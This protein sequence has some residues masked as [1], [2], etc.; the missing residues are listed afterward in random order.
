[1]KIGIANDLHFGMTGEA[2]YNNRIFYDCVEEITESWVDAYNKEELD[3]VIVAGDVTEE[4]GRAAL[5]S[6]HRVL[7]QLTAPWYAIPGN[8]DWKSV[9]D[10]S[11]DDVLRGRRPG[12]YRR[13]EEIGMLFFNEGV[14]R[15][16]EETMNFL[17][18]PETMDLYLSAVEQD[19]PHTLLIFSHVPLV[20]HAD[21]PQPHNGNYGG[22]Y[23]NGL[24]LLEKLATLLDRRIV[25]FSAHVHFHRIVESAKWIQCTTGGMLEYPME[26]RIAVVENDRLRLSVLQGAPRKL[27]EAS[28]VQ[29]WARGNEQD[30]LG[31]FVL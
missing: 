13:Y 3:L 17:I 11:F 28:M 27:A 5:E 12:T 26:G 2:I 14:Q 15:D 9:L 1:M 24:E 22:H 31:E 25:V 29:A 8:H 10:G 21:R 18:T 4:Q 7:S 23:A 30:R 19:R 6:A 20:S 16:G